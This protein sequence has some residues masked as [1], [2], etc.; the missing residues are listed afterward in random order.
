MSAQLAWLQL[1]DALAEDAVTFAEQHPA[2]Y[3]GRLA[4]D[5]FG[6]TRTI[7]YSRL[8]MS[9]SRVANAPFSQWKA[10]SVDMHA[11]GSPVGATP[12]LLSGRLVPGSPSRVGG[13]CSGRRPPHR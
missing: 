12:F 10:K 9:L 7:A 8:P 6:H 3:A 1:I 11:G 4:F 13:E 2:A 5:A